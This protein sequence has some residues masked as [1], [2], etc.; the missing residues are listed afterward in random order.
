MGS[1]T[2]RSVNIGQTA[3]NY[4]IQQANLAAQSVSA[5]G[6]SLQVIEQVGVRGGEINI[7]GSELTGG[8]TV[9]VDALLKADQSNTATQDMSIFMEQLSKATVSGIALSQASEAINET[10]IA[11]NSFMSERNDALQDC[12]STGSASQIIRQVDGA[13]SKINIKNTKITTAVNVVA[14]CVTDVVQKN[15]AMQKLELTLKQSATAESAGLDMTAFLGILLLVI[16]GLGVLLIVVAFAIKKAGGAIVSGVG[17]TV[18]RVQEFMTKPIVLF[19]ILGGVIGIVVYVVLINKKAT[20]QIPTAQLPDGSSDPLAATTP[21]VYPFLKLEALEGKSDPEVTEGVRRETWIE[22]SIKLLGDGL[23]E[24]EVDSYE[25]LLRK[26][27]PKEEKDQDPKFAK[28]TVVY[29]NT[30]TKRYKLFE[31]KPAFQEWSMWVTKTDDELKNVKQKIEDGKV[32]G[33][34]Y[35]TEPDGKPNPDYNDPNKCKPQQGTYLDFKDNR[36]YWQTSKFYVTKIMNEAQVLFDQLLCIGASVFGQVD[37]ESFNRPRDFF[38]Q[39][40]RGIKT[41]Y[42]LAE[43]G[44]DATDRTVGGWFGTAARGVAN[45]V[46]SADTTSGEEDF[47]AWLKKREQELK[48]KY[49]IP[50]KLYLPVPSDPS[51]SHNRQ[52]DVAWKILFGNSDPSG[53]TLNPENDATIRVCTRDLGDNEDPS[54]QASLDKCTTTGGDAYI[55]DTKSIV[56]KLNELYK[57]VRGQPGTNLIGMPTTNSL[58]EEIYN[59][60]PS[61]ARELPEFQTMVRD[62]TE[63]RSRLLALWIRKFDEWKKYYTLKDQYKTGDIMN[64]LDQIRDLTFFYPSRADET[65]VRLGTNSQGEPRTVSPM[66]FVAVISGICVIVFIV[67]LVFR[68]YVVTAANREKIKELYQ[69]TAEKLKAKLQALKEKRAV[70]KVEADIK[71][72]EMTAASKESSTSSATPEPEPAPALSTSPEPAK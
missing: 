47:V 29:Y 18:T 70:A 23:G 13:E 66:F 43:K 4:S 3:A 68:K 19:I 69:N 64:N 34:C 26:I 56:H 62:A 40:E 11:I 48:E 9:N 49:K 72:I 55:I 24:G 21:L 12:E 67:L 16:V 53:N 60:M 7:E 38:V 54:S 14:K 50:E 28:V 37:P 17:R 71:Q 8:V 57:L 39:C 15:D 20:R 52:L 61:K 44:Q 45:F 2:S 41:I 35:E 33:V 42:E 51:S 63:K 1:Q 36:R 59:K 22:G 31:G 5:I 46:F 32:T 25:E 6:T 58:A 65:A 10:R 27:A 30:Q